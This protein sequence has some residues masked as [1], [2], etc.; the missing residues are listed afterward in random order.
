VCYG[1]ERLIF[2]ITFVATL[3]LPLLPTSDLVVTLHPL[4]ISSFSPW[5]GQGSS[6]SDRFVNW[7]LYN[8]SPANAKRQKKNFGRHWDRDLM[9]RM[10]VYFFLFQSFNF[11]RFLLFLPFLMYVTVLTIWNTVTKHAFIQ[12]SKFKTVYLLELL[13]YIPSEYKVNHKV[14]NLSHTA[15]L[16]N[17]KF[18]SCQFTAAAESTVGVAGCRYTQQIKTVR[19]SW[20]GGQDTNG[21]RLHTEQLKYVIQHPDAIC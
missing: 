8:N 7:Q 15:H 11:F 3:S 10:C 12:E 17:W 5:A 4:F 16:V 9:S 13:F 19:T 21:G 1:N 2:P 14:H 20:T 6:H 18:Y